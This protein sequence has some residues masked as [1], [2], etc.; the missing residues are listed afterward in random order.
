MN[1]QINVSNALDKRAVERIGIELDPVTHKCS[2]SKSL[3]KV[4]AISP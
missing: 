1:L 3:A 2:F 4:P